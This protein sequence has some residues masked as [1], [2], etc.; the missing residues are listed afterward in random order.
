MNWLK[1]QIQVPGVTKRDSL[2]FTLE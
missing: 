1:N 2:F